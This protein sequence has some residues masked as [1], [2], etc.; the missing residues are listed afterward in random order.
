[1]VDCEPSPASAASISGLGAA[2]S[3]QQDDGVNADDGLTAP[4][5]TA[6]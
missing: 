3:L 2:M 1:M 5:R 6:P 4:A